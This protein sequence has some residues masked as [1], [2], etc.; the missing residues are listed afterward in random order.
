MFD[1]MALEEPARK[2]AGVDVSLCANDELLAAAVGLE[3]V[4]SLI[5]VAEGYVLAELERR[6][7][8]EDEF[9]HTTRTWLARAAKV[10]QRRRVIRRQPAVGHR[11]VD[12]RK[13]GQ[14]RRGGHPGGRR[15]GGRPATPD[16]N[17]PAPP[18]PSSAE[19]LLA[20]YTSDTRADAPVPDAASGGGPLLVLAVPG[21]RAVLVVDRAA[22]LTRRLSPS[23]GR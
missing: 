12:Q 4:R 17:R 21:E 18:L 1:L 19:P 13:P 22:V 2:A 8:C 14:L 7:V 9:G 23:A 15:A 5:D 10:R 6:G 20:V 16:P 11:R 3:R